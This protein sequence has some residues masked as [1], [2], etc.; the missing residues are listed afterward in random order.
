MKQTRSTAQSKAEVAFLLPGGAHHGA[1]Q[2]VH[3][4]DPCLEEGLDSPLKSWTP[5]EGPR[6][7]QQQI[8]LK[9]ACHGA[10]CEPVPSPD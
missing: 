6:G 1:G 3:P 9:V 10:G 8:Q 5:G 7:P 2:P 4:A